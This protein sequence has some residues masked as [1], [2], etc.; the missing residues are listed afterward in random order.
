[1]PLQWPGADDAQDAAF[2]EALD[3]GY[4][5]YDT[6]HVEPL[7]PFGY[8]LSYTT[9]AYSH[10]RIQRTRSRYAVSF[11]VKNTGTRAGVE[12]PQLYVDDPRI[13]GEPP[14]QLKGYQR[15]Y[16]RPHRSV[17]VTLALDARSLSYWDVASAK[18]RVAPGLY[19]IL[20]GASSRD[21]RLRGFVRR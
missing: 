20:I 11:T 4:R 5:W 10:L 18:W 6:H 3:V 16:L 14:K 15:V 9:F 12:V 1:M 19:R 7:F 17:R 8:G 21:I 13:A 2:V